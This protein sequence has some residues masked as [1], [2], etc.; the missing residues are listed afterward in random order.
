MPFN[1]ERDGPIDGASGELGMA[2]FPIES[3]A[4]N[5]IHA[6]ERAEARAIG[7]RPRLVGCGQRGFENGNL[8][9]AIGDLT[10]SKMQELARRPEMQT[11]D[12]PLRDI[13]RETK[14][15][16]ATVA[17]RHAV[18]VL[19]HVARTPGVL[20]RE[21]AWRSQ[22]PKLFGNILEG[23]WRKREIRCVGQLRAIDLAGLQ[24]REATFR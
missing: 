18:D 13:E 9:I 16:R 19:R 15:D 17:E 24:L 1:F 23:S 11:R 20:E 22:R 21:R 7:Q 3:A 12:L 2:M 5:A 10:K 6:Q 14:H 4:R 8:G